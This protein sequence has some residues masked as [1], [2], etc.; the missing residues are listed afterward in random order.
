MPANNNIA[1]KPSR[2]AAKHGAPSVR[3]WSESPPFVVNRR[4][5]LTHRVKHVTNYLRGVVVSH[6]HADYLC[7]NGCNF[8]PN[9]TLAVLV[10]DPP[11][12]RL[13]C[14]FCEAK[15]RRNKLPSGDDLAGRHVHRGVCVPQRVCCNE[16]GQK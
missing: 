15:A 8:D 11:A 2:T 14:D 1:L 13:L 5:V 16:A 9:D 4:G 6:C 3:P 12:D 10:P 7:G